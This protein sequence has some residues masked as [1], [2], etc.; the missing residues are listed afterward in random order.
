[1]AG[2][3]VGRLKW[4][5][6]R[7]PVFYLVFATLL[8]TLLCWVTPPFFGPDEPNQSLRALTLLHA[9]VLPEMAA[10]EAGGE[11]DTG[12]VDAMNGVDAI[13]MRW[14]KRSADFHDRT[15]GPMTAD[16]QARWAGVGWSGRRDFVAFGNTATYPPGLYLPEMVGWKI[17]EAAKLSIFASL[18]LARWLMALSAVLLGWL[19]LRRA[20][21]G[22][23]LLL[24]GLLLPSALFLAATC[25]P[26]ALAV[27]LVS[28]AVAI[29]WRALHE[30]RVLSVPELAVASVVL[31]VCAVARP[32]YLPLALLIFVPLAEFGDQLPRRW[33]APAVAF[34]A[35]AVGCATW[36]RLVSRF[37]L[38][39]ADEANPARQLNY[40]QHHPIGAAC[41]VGRGTAEAAWDLMHRGLYVVGWNDLLPHHGAALLLSAAL[42]AIAVSAPGLG[43]RRWR[44]RLLMLAAAGL[45]LVAISLAEYLIWTP[46]GLGTVYGVQP[47]YWLPVLPGLML[48]ATSWRGRERNRLQWLL[49][50]AAIVLAVVA[51]TLPWMEARAFYRMGLTDVLRINLH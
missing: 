30:R 38:D 10:G 32:P 8:G 28:V 17:A 40:L 14:E 29:V 46:P 49:P 35:I 9:H 15:Y 1:M 44:S 21:D 23:W 50:S 43:V 3:R 33:L 18:R 19:A 13:R 27:S 36:W 24:P 5:E 41:A 45:P 31:G 6:R 42:L 7:L 2:V 51:C 16:L 20:A 26:D 12:A 4:M 47:R 22:A 48:L 11:V 39:T 25:S 34:T 37:G